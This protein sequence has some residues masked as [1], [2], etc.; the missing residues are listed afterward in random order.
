VVGRRVPVDAFE[1]SDLAIERQPMKPQVRGEPVLKDLLF[2]AHKL[3]TPKQE[4][5]RL[6]PVSAPAVGERGLATPSVLELHFESLGKLTFRSGIQADA[7]LKRHGCYLAVGA[8]GG[9]FDRNE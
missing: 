4:H 6:I 8:G 2:T 3:V 9:D 5:A 1:G 7:T